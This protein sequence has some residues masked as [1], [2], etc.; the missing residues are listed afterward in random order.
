MFRFLILNLSR[1]LQLEETLLKYCSPVAI[2]QGVMLY[3]G[4]GEAPEHEIIPKIQTENRLA[5]S[6]S[7]LAYNG[8]VI[9]PRPFRTIGSVFRFEDLAN[10]F[11]MICSGDGMTGMNSDEQSLA[12]VYAD[13][14]LQQTYEELP[15]EDVKQLL[16]KIVSNDFKN[17]F[18]QKFRGNEALVYL[19]DQ[20]YQSSDLALFPRS[21][22]SQSSIDQNIRIFC[23]AW[24]HLNI[25]TGKEFGVTIID[26]I[27]GIC[28]A[29]IG[30]ERE[31][32]EALATDVK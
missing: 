8:D 3:R 17:Q 5:M 14:A 12:N 4:I 21:S 6:A 20:D 1:R 16:E 28:K 10:R 22:S 30:K 31:F 24:N 15:L 9:F 26:P 29:K 32:I 2:S 18:F 19:T 27:M 23:R 11:G 7:L 13:E 25:G